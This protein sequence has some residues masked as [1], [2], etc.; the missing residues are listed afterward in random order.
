MDAWEKAKQHCEEI[1]SLHP[2]HAEAYN[3]LAILYEKK[4]DYSNALKNYAIAVNLQPDYI[5][6]HHNLGLFFLKHNQIDAAIVQFSNVLE[7]NASLSTHYYLGNCYL[8]KNQLDLAKEQYLEALKFSPE[9][10]DTLNNLGVTCLKKEESQLAID[11]FTKALAY[12]INHEDARN[13]LAAT[14]MQYDRYENAA[15]HYR[16]LLQNHPENTEYHYNIAVAYMNLGH[17]DE[18]IEHFESVLAKNPNHPAS[19][20]NLAAVYWRLGKKSKT[21]ILLSRA[22]EVEPENQASQ[23]LLSAATHQENYTQ[24]PEEYV[25]NLFDNYAIQYDNHLCQELHYQLPAKIGELLSHYLPPQQKLN[26]ILDLGCGTGLLGQYLKNHCHNLWGVDLSEKMLT[27]AKKIGWYDQL[28]C[29]E[30]LHF[31][32]NTTEQFDLIAAGEVFEYFGDLSAIFTMIAKRLSPRGLFI[33]S[34]EPTTEKEDF[35]LQETARFAHNTEYIQYLAEK[36]HLKIVEKISFSARLQ[37]HKPLPS[38]LFLFQTI[39]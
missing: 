8:A 16:E 5:I 32:R 3:N 33:C 21:K 39:I 31:L 37:N 11:Y 12:D 30:V 23:Y 27:Y 18:A 24:A 28:Y 13:N 14:F 9:H 25:K 20:N 36:N 6:A 7:L 4:N 38:Y 34:I 22:L 1:I 19:L 15:R 35:I 26:T 10:S 29:D 17:L 2:E